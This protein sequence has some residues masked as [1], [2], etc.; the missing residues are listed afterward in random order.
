MKNI[1]LLEPTQAALDMEY[2]PWNP[3][4]DKCFGMVIK[5]YNE[6]A[7]RAIAQGN[8]GD[9]GHEWVKQRNGNVWMDNA[10][11]KCEKIGVAD[12]DAGDLILKHVQYA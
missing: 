12:D 5:A 4:Y 10:L 2:G 7:A 3:W 9:E 6:A 8:A 11:T 1:Y